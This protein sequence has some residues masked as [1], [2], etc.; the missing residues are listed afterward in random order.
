MTV[1]TLALAGCDIIDGMSMEVDGV[2]VAAHE[3]KAPLAVLR[4]LALGLDGLNTEGEQIRSEMVNVSER[5]LRQVND[6]IKIKRLDDGLFVMEPVAVRGICDEVVSELGRLFNGQNRKIEVRYCNRHR[7]VN[8]NH[9]LLY[10]VIYNFAVNAMHY[11]DQKTQT[12][13]RVGDCQ[14]KI[15][16]T[17][18]DY[19]PMLPVE[20][21]RKLR[22]G[23]IEEPV[24]MALRS[25]SSG[26]GLYI[27]SKFSRYMEAEVGAIRHRDGTSFYVA[28]PISKQMRLW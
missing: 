12:L 26:L 28:L 20:I 2:L 9:E 18:R 27:A 17:V 5:A 23:W 15:K 8:A 16:V 13:I 1:A 19:G 3:L 11:S 22:Q 24:E 25:G 10:S 21:W 14:D 6:L 7:L 4:Q